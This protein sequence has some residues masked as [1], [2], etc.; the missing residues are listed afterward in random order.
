MF[1]LWGITKFTLDKKI[2]ENTI[3]N[4]R[5]LNI[6]RRCCIAQLKQDVG[7]KS[8]GQLSMVFISVQIQ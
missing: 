4:L 3:E 1:A 8:K 6:V 5:V 2:I 7:R